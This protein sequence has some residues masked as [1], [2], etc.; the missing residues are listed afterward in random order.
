MTLNN[1]L[2]AELKHEG[3][4]TRKILSRIPEEHFNWKPHE[5]SMTLGKLAC[6]IADL[7][8]WAAL[9]TTV[10]EFD[11]IKTPL[12]RCAATD[13]KELLENF[14]HNLE[15]AVTALQNTSDKILEE[16]WILR[17]GEF[18]VVNTTRKIAL[19]SMLM[20]HIIHHRGQLTVYLRLL[21]IPVP[22][23]Y[24]PSADEK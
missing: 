9:I 4:N 19:R 23:M 14:E 2:A 16:N 6:H 3:A 12:N 22:G 13:A 7:T 18:I 8:Q 24:G 1:T 10:A 21:N 5:K 17:R 20:N 15:Q 11:F